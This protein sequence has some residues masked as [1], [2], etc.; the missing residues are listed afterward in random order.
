KRDWSSD[1]CSSDLWRHACCKCQHND[2]GGKYW[3]GLELHNFPKER[4]HISREDIETERGQRDV[5]GQNHHWTSLSANGGS[6][7]G[8]LSGV[9]F[10]S[11]LEHRGFT[12]FPTDPEGNEA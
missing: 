10:A 7:R 9:I 5:T 6:Q 8:M 3:H 11:F 12:E 4:R 2:V 1:V